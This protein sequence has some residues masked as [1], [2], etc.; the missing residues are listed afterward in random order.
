MI[1][2]I[3]CVLFVYDYREYNDI[4]NKYQ[5]IVST[6]GDVIISHRVA[7]ALCT[8]RKPLACIRRL[9]GVSKMMM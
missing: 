4:I 5:D 2:V 1:N 9:F 8:T 7:G 6:F 3:K